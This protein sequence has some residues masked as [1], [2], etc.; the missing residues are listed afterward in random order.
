METMTATDSSTAVA[1]SK[2]NGFGAA[3]PAEYPDRVEYSIRPHDGRARKPL[4]EQDLADL[5]VRAQPPDVVD[6]AGHYTEPEAD[7]LRKLGFSK[8][9]SET[10]PVMVTPIITIHGTIN[11]YEITP[12][13]P[14]YDA[15]GK[16]RKRELIRNW[17]SC[18]YASPVT[19]QH[20]D[21]PLIDMLLTESIHKA[22]AGALW[23]DAEVFAVASLGV[24]GTRGKNKY[25]GIAPLQDFDEIP[26]KG[27]DKYGVDIA[28][29]VWLVPDS[30]FATNPGVRAATLQTR[31]YLERRGARVPII[32][33]PPGPGG[34]SQGLDDWCAQHPKATFADLRSLEFKEGSPSAALPPKYERRLDGMFLNG[35]SR[36]GSPVSTQLSNFTV[37]IVQE[38]KRNDGV[39]EN[40]VY[41][42]DLTCKGRTETAV[43][44]NKGFD[45][46]GWIGEHFGSVPIVLAGQGIRDH[47]RVAIHSGPEP[48]RRTVYTHTGWTNVRGVYQYLH[49][50]G[51][52]G[53]SP[54]VEVD[55]PPQLSAFNIPAASRAEIAAGMLSSLEL[56]DLA[57]DAITVPLLCCVYRAV[58][59]GCDFGAHIHGHTGLFK[60]ELAALALQHYG[61]DFSSRGMISWTSTANFIQMIAF[62]AKDTVLPI[63]DLYGPSVGF[64]EKQRQRVAVDRVFRE[65][66]NASDRGRLNADSTLKPPKPSRCLPISTGEEGLTGESL[67]SR[68]W[69][70]PIAEDDTGR[71]RMD[72]ARLTAAQKAAREG[73]FA[74]A[75]RGY[76]E[77]LTPKYE[78]IRD[79]L[80]NRISEYRSK[81]VAEIGVAHARTST[82]VADLFV[83]FDTFVAAALGYGAIPSSQA[84]EYKARVWSALISGASLQ[85]QSQ[86]TQEP[87]RRFLDLLMSAV[88]AG[89]AFLAPVKS[90]QEAEGEDSR[91]YIWRY[92]HSTIGSK[93][94]WYDNCDVY[95]DPDASY[96]AARDVAPDG[97]TI[98]VETLKRRLKD[99]KLLATTGTDT[100][101]Q[102]VTVRRTIEG[103]RREVL[104][105]LAATLGFSAPELDATE[106]AEK[107]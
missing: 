44:P 32:G 30:N 27:R 90:P 83:G 101:R 9:Q 107:M 71:G 74:Y 7:E 95:L 98:S 79:G 39:E 51:S 33:L 62:H 12:R 77:C 102:S 54:E 57:P 73:K 36:D 104:H 87:A 25:G 2:T 37:S 78:D 106:F 29:T 24:T 50:G 81:A 72:L 40:H 65:K 10:V 82:M 46:L 60:S 99:Q 64:V 15:K 22:N 105:L 63:D 20:K 91:R 19:L 6:A 35:T 13:N 48:L 5:L 55:L 42:V 70:I 97:I 59:G 41:Q 8:E 53:G 80:R 1:R 66:G 89:K 28:R 103:R 43:V 49:A 23:P 3:R 14:R 75:M 94:G 76:I 4:S 34:K 52:I 61:R 56:L 93:V 38:I 86:A 100:P 16:P 18:L 84:N 26:F 17:R 11:G 88:S 67:R 58:L 92:G 31:A 45:N 96:K 68:V 21:N 85:T 47:A 69:D